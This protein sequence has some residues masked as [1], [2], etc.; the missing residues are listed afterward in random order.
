LTLLG[1][2]VGTCLSSRSIPAVPVV[3]DLAV[4]FA[5]FCRGPAIAKVKKKARAK[6]R[7]SIIT[8]HVIDSLE[9]VPLPENKSECE[10]WRSSASELED[11]WAWKSEEDGGT[12]ALFS[13]SFSAMA[14]AAE[15]PNPRPSRVSAAVPV[16]VPAVVPMTVPTLALAAALKAK[17][18]LAA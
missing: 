7:Q 11:A 10:A 8:T 3:K 14:P 12:S 1:G 17:T 15:V 18:S 16:V 13:C 9:L 5:E 2:R 6:A 4:S